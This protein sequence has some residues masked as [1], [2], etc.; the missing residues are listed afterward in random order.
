MNPILE[1]QRFG[2]DSMPAPAKKRRMDAIASQVARIR[3][4]QG[5]TQ[6]EMAKKL[7]TSQ[8]VY[9]KYER[10]ELRLHADTLQQIAKILGVTPNELFGITDGGAAKKAATSDEN[11]PK[12]FLR[13]LRGVQN[14]TRTDQ[15]YLLRTIDMFVQ[16]AEKNGKRSK[17]AK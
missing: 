15:D 7:K 11:I 2:L 16:G 17:A 10:G 4:E 14:L 6:I 1:Q 5:F 3:K 13:R 9:S 8:S 12:R